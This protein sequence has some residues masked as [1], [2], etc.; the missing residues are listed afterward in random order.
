MPDAKALMLR[1]L[2]TG[3]TDSEIA[4]Q[5]GIL[6][7][8]DRY[9]LDPVQTESD[10]REALLM[11]AP[12]CPKGCVPSMTTIAAPPRRLVGAYLKPSAPPMGWE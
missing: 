6:T 3:E 4:R 11:L 2:A 7:V 12:V 1:W 9:L 8:G 10:T 5:C